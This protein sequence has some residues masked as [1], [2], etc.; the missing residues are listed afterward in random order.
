MPS[1]SP[2]FWIRS[3]DKDG[4]QLGGPHTPDFEVAARSEESHRMAFRVG[5]VSSSR[6]LNVF[7][8]SNSQHIA[9]VCVVLLQALSST[10]I[11]VLTSPELLKEIQREFK[12][13]QTQ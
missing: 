3:E 7:W 5:K 4:K 12:E 9:N 8:A 6:S 13:L 11:D 10:A 2:N 1:I